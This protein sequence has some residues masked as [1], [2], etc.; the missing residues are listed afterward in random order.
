MI[1]QQVYDTA[2][3]LLAHLY[4]LYYSLLQ[5]RRRLGYVIGWELSEVNHGTH[6]PILPYSAD[7]RALS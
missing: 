2:F 6:R 7:T 5:R 4:Y 3:D 1:Q